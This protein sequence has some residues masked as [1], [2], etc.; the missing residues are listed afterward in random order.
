[1]A[2]RTKRTTRIASVAL[3]GTTVF[4]NPPPKLEKAPPDVIVNR[5]N[6]AY[7]ARPVDAGTSVTVAPSPPAP[8]VTINR[9]PVPMQEPADAGV[10][11]LKKK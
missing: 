2:K 8:R 9:M 1:M 3:L 4:A 6:P 7:D 11:E 10:R 5:P